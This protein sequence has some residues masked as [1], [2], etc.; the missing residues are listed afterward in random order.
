MENINDVFSYESNRLMNTR[1]A[2][3]YL[4]YKVGSIYNLVLKGEL[5][6]YKCGMRKKSPLRFMK[7]D[8]DVF[9]GK[10]EKP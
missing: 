10:K 4:G 6:P 7:N 8:L 1:E 3:Y 2:A 9:L 5:R